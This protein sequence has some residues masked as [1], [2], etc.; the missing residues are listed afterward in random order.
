MHS[1]VPTCGVPE[2]PQNKFGLDDNDDD[3]ELWFRN[4]HHAVIVP[5]RQ[6]LLHSLE[7]WN[8]C[9]S[10]FAGLT[11]DS[12]RERVMLSILGGFRPLGSDLSAEVIRVTT[13]GTR[14][15]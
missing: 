8:N 11:S 14:S 6:L 12:E 1:L 10:E 2:Y 7:A 15:A 4:T 5:V 13:A 9:L 3:Y